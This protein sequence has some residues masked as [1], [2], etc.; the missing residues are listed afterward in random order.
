MTLDQLENGAVARIASIGVL[1][2]DL[3]VKLREMGFCEG[4]EVELL[5]TGPLGGQ[6]LAVRLNRRIVALR[7]GEA[8]SIEIEPGR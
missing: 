5:A 2:P 7:R 8:A 1:D 3:E 6:P 4:D